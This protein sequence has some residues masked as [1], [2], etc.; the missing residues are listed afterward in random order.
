[1]NLYWFQA[2]SN[3]FCTMDGHGHLHRWSLCL[4]SL[5]SSWFE[6]RRNRPNERH[7]SLIVSGGLARNAARARDPRSTAATST[8]EHNTLSQ[9]GAGRSTCNFRHPRSKLKK[10]LI[11]PKSSLKVSAQQTIQRLPSF[12]ID[13]TFLGPDSGGSSQSPAWLAAT[14]K[15]WTDDDWNKP[16]PRI[17]F[18]GLTGAGEETRFEIVQ[19]RRKSQL[20]SKWS[21]K[22]KILQ[23]NGQQGIFS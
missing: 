16:V 5:H 2:A 7:E 14:I 15:T 19:H 4:F 20:G 21:K 11:L 12:I 10:E 13:P 3:R 17:Y 8:T 22:N 6:D 9:F 18:R 1:M 23:G